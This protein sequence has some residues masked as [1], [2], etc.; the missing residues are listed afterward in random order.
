M[1]STAKNLKDLVTER[2]GQFA[3]DLDSIRRI[4]ESLQ[5]QVLALHSFVLGIEGKEHEN[6]IAIRLPPLD[7]GGL[8][9]MGQIIDEFHRALETPIRRLG[10][11]SVR[12]VGV[13]KGSSVVELVASASSIVTFVALLVAKWQEYLK[14]DA[15]IRAVEAKV[16]ALEL[17][18]EIAEQIA[19]NREEAQAQWLNRQAVNV[20]AE[21]VPDET[22]EVRRNGETVTVVKE[23]IRIGADLLRRGSAVDLRRLEAIEQSPGLLLL[24][25]PPETFLLGPAAAAVEAD[26]ASAASP[27]AAEGSVAASTPVIPVATQSTPPTKKQTKRSR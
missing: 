20:V 13:S 16:R 14:H 12:V 19:R 10:L 4:F 27:S 24:E 2:D 8:D 25:A 21:V 23:S 5:A 17:S 11:G 18:T 7:G 6:Q 15:E 1:L 3:S 26:A 22:S 9:G